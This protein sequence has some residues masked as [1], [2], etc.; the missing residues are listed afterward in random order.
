MKVVCLQNPNTQTECEILIDA[1]YDDIIETIVNA[2]G[3]P[4]EDCERIELC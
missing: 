3:D 1:Y 4:Q 2:Y